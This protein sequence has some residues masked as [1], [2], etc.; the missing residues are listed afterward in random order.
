M[1]VIALT[2]WFLVVTPKCPA[3]IFSQIPQIPIANGAIL[4][5]SIAEFTTRLRT[6]ARQAVL[7]FQD[8][9]AARIGLNA[10]P[11]PLRQFKP[12]D[13]VAVSRRG[14]GL[15]RSSACWRGPGVVAGETGGNYWVSMPG[16]FIKRSPEQLRLRTA[17][18]READRFLVRDLRAA[19]ASLYPEV[20]GSM[21]HILL[22]NQ[23][24]RETC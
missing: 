19:A 2:N 18:E 8:H 7:S 21:R 22:K 23:C 14:R 15:K 4:E 20:G 17:E 3:M 6:T 24:H 9:R 16:S 11:R 1:V 13:E 10:R 5:D 12:G